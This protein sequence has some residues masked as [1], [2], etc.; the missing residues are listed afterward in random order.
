MEALDYDE[1]GT[2]RYGNAIG[3]IHLDRPGRTILLEAT[4]TM[5]NPA[6]VSMDS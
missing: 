1:I 2:D 6:I 3:A 5:W 4:W